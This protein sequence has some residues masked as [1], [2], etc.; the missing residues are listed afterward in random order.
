MYHVT[1]FNSK[2]C[3]VSYYFSFLCMLLTL[4]CHFRGFKTQLRFTESA[5]EGVMTLSF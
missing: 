3:F 1:L 2:M 4:G 5:K